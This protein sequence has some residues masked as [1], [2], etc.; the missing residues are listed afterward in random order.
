M[1]TPAEHLLAYNLQAKF[2]A[3]APST[4]HE[5]ADLYAQKHHIFALIA[6]R[7]RQ[8]FFHRNVCQ[9]CHE[10]PGQ[11]PG[12]ATAHVRMRTRPT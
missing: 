1:P 3:R 9:N 5:I 6:H 11:P 2:D 12:P 10:L 4:P 8:E 7:Y